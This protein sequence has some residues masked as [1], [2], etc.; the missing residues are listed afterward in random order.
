MRTFSRVCLVLVLA[1]ALL[2]AGAA[3]AA[4][5]EVSG[6]L[7]KWH[8]V[9]LTFD[10]PE[11]SE[12]G[13]PNPFM[14]YRL[15]VNFMNGE[16][17]YA[18][19]GYF[20]ADGDAA[21]TSADSGK[22]WRAHFAPDAE[23]TWEYAVSFRQGE[24]VAVSDDPAAGEPVAGLDGLTGTFEIGPTDKTGRDFR[25]HGRLQ[26]VGE[27]YLRFAETGEYFLK[28]GADA[29]ENLL[30]Y[31]D[32]DGDFKT[33][34]QKDNFI[35]TWS[36]HVTDWREGDPMWQDGKGKGLIG[37]INYLASEG[38]NAFSFLT[39]NIG[40]DDR[41]VFP[42]T[43]YAERYRMDVSRLDQWE[44]VF[45]HGQKLGMYL[46]FK[47]QETEN[48]QLLD[49][50]D[51]GPQ[52]RL[53]YRELIARFGHHLALNWNLGEENSQTTPQRI[54]MTE[55]FWT[56][57][58]YRHLVVIHNGK[59]PQD[60]LGDVSKLTGFSLQT[61][62]RT[63]NQVHRR[64]LRWVRASAEAGKPW[65]VACDEPGDAS[66]AL[67]P[68]SDD[69]THDDARRNGLWGTLLAG[70]AGNEWYF[71]YQHDHSD[72]T[73]E[74][75]RSRDLWW[76]QCRHALEFFRNNAVPFHEMTNAN[77]KLGG[78]QGYCFCKEGEVY[79]IFLHEAGPA[80]L[81]LTGVE[82]NFEVAWYNPRT[83]GDLLQGSLKEIAGGGV[84]QLGSPPGEEPASDWV[85]LIQDAIIMNRRPVAEAGPDQALVDTD[86]DGVVQVALDGT[87]S[88]DPDG[89]IVA[90]DWYNAEPE[91]AGTKTYSEQD[92]VVCIEVE[93][94][95]GPLGAWVRHTDNRQYRWLDGF[96]GEGCLQFTGNTEASGAPNSILSFRL[97]IETAGTYG[98]GIR[99]LEAPMETGQGDKANDCYV[100]LVGQS[101]WEGEFKKFVF[102]GSSYDW[103]WTVTGEPAHHEFRMPRYKLDKGTHLLQIA[104]R[105]K[106]FFVD[107]IVLWT[108]LADAPNQ[109]A[110]GKRADELGALPPSASFVGGRIAEGPSPTIELPPGETTLTLEVTDDRFGKDTD[111]MTVSIAT[112]PGFPR[113]EAGED[114]VVTDAEDDGA[115]EVTLDGAAST[116]GDHEIAEHAWLRDGRELA[117]GA[118]A[119]VTLPVGEHEITLAITDRAGQTGTDTVGVTVKPYE[120]VV[121]RLRPVEDA[122]LQ[123]GALHA[124]GELRVERDRRV[125][126]LKFDV[127]EGTGPIE[128]AALRI[129]VGTDPGRGRLRV[130]AG[131]HTEWSEE[132]LSKET[133]PEPGPPLDAF[134]GTMGV[135]GTVELDVSELV[136]GPGSYSLVLT[137][138]QGNDVSFKA[139]ETATAWPE[140]MLTIGR[141]PD[142]SE[143]RNL[144]TPEEE[145]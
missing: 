4:S 23:G 88:H 30:A 27:H 109:S 12:Q 61:S 37:A 84:A 68:D 130:H 50:G 127:A 18:V 74:D 56:H 71:G 63:F 86:N 87:A 121:I 59:S 44:I 95:A 120:P 57:D 110:V 16:S 89:E 134:S 75:F 98:I 25:A 83:G 101:G 60:L 102:L 51:V 112:P 5:P 123:N 85:A 145:R 73:C 93:D 108:D 7:K 141:A 118:R 79:V 26:Y 52:R 122:Y 1:P 11:C 90:W 137:M 45:E 66:H 78:A 116:P 48:D 13:A 31:A 81:D 115:H 126:Y 125:S 136:D 76:D 132:S 106:N 43:S 104:G 33:D 2:A 28:Q 135:G 8:K 139:S 3:R 129:T 140:L 10:G 32:F 35:K 124:E 82:G 119:D 29:P 17:R 107:R 6:E 96:H 92:G 9:T 105:S 103:R 42:Y 39:M 114:V 70:G 64:V 14:D 72:L 69:P 55:Y 34:G 54:A 20:A 113:A 99:A 49:G 36:P 47:T 40:G 131:S 24:G 21:N 19:P 142:S 117:R 97:D 144:K 58:P 77:E 15:S 94:A 38:M 41:N 46:H 22:K 128:T 143:V 80:T 65:V 53:Y 138:D 67:V 62:S 91:T 111:T 100:R 133:A